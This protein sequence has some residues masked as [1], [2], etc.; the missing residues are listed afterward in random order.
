MLSFLT[1]SLMVMPFTFPSELPPGDSH[2]TSGLAARYWTTCTV[3]VREYGCPVIAK[4]EGVNWTFGI[5][6][7]VGET[8]QNHYHISHACTRC[9]IKHCS[10]NITLPATLRKYEPLLEI[11]LMYCGIKNGVTLASQT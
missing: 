9:I 11:F 2:V 10:K 5:G 8:M 7:A 6:R 4:V 3:Q 1:A